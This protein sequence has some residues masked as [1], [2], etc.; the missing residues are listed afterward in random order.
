MHVI[1]IDDD[2]D[3]WHNAARDALAHGWTPESIEWRVERH[4]AAA[5]S[6]FDA[7]TD[8]ETAPPKPAEASPV[9]ISK[10]LASQLKDASHFRDPNRWGFLY[11]VLW[12]WAQGDRSSASPAD[13]DGARL[14]KMAKSVRR[15]QHDMIAYVR[16]RQRDASL[17]PPEYVAWYEPDHDVLAWGAEHFAARMGR[18]TWLITTPDGAAMFDVAHLHLERRRNFAADH[19]CDTPDAAE[20]LWM[21]YYRSIF[22]PARLNES[23]LE[24]HMPV[25]F[26]KGLPEGA[27]IPSLVSQ[28]RGGV[29]RVG[30]AQHVGALGGKAV[31]VDALDAQPARDAPTSLDDCRRCDL[32]RHA[33]QAVAGEGP[34]DARI[35]L[36]GEQPGDQEDLKGEPFVGPAGQLLDDAMRRA[37]VPREQVYL[38][39]AV[40]HFKWEPRGKRRLH[41][42]PGQ[43]EVEACAYWLER[44][45]HDIGAR[46]IVT[47]GATALAALLGHRAT[48][49]AHL[50]RVTP[51]GDKVIVATY[52]PS[53]ALRQ[54]DDAAREKNVAAIVAALEQARSL[55]G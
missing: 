15:V 34:S 20:A 21:T 30:Q 44:E 35:M 51:Y 40:K 19:Q 36:L 10:E 53:Y 46:V 32:W 42:T 27:L 12:R 11:R 7:Q 48:L 28:A 31:Q 18:S 23:A 1:S 29:R 26:W 45:L 47:L 52:H 39:N 22:N 5:L 41:K 3:A 24:Q 13:E 17:G 8:A 33:T 49:Q 25:R 55:T 54:N 43:Q 16:F 14:N 38:T 37:G 9:R 50:G 4:D 6:L 2:F